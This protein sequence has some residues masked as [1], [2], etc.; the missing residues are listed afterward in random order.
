MESGVYAPINGIRCAPINGIRCLCTQMSIHL[1]V[2][3]FWGFRP[4][5][6]SCFWFRGPS[7]PI[8]VFRAV[9]GPGV[10]KTRHAPL[11]VSG[12]ITRGIAVFLILAGMGGLVG[13]V[14]AN[15]TTFPYVKIL[16]PQTPFVEPILVN[17]G[18]NFS[19]VCQKVQEELW[20][21]KNIKRCGMNFLRY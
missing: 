17:F 19:V 20:M 1:S 12:R 10:K 3:L 7:I 8:A 2:N 21:R 18:G 15:G 4:R 5:R 9:R 11:H 16:V 6:N 14:I 13:R